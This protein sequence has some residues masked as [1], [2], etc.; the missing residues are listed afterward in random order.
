MPASLRLQE[1]YGDDLAVVFV[2]SQGASPEAAEAFAWKRKWMATGALWTTERPLRVEGRS[3]PKFALLGNHGELLLSGNPLAMKKDIERAIAE[4][5]ER[6]HDAPEGTPKGLHEAWESFLRG[7]VADAL[8]RCDAA[9]DE[10]ELAEEARA[11]REAFVARA[12]ARIAHVAR[13]ADA[14]RLEL[15]QERLRELEQGAEG[16]SELSEALAEQRARIEEPDAALAAEAEAADALAK[17]EERMARGKPFERANLERLEKLREKHP[18][19][20]AAARAAHL[21]DLAAL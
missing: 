1:E 2:E 3:L 4:Q 14:G 6:R 7:R 10:P 20:R 21:L 15:A 11:L 12:R 8:T 17:I 16:V 19:T 9:A 5:V 18:G 13:L